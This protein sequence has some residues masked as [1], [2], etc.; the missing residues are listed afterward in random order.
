[1]TAWALLVGP[2]QRASIPPDTQPW[3]TAL[4]VRTV[5]PAPGGA[6]QH[7][8]FVLLSEQV[9]PNARSTVKHSTSPRQ[10]HMYVLD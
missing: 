9:N 7:L 6:C 1:M 3:T 8:T 2:A 10:L 4:A 5:A